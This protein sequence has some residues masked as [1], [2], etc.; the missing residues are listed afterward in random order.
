MESNETISD[1]FTRFTDII[2]GLKSLGKVYTNVEMVKQ[3][4]QVSTKKLKAKS[5]HDRKG[6]IPQ[7]NGP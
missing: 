3:N 6:E 2:N 5:D 4:S 7:K 1:M